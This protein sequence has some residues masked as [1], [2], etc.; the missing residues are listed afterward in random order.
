MSPNAPAS[1]LGFHTL[2]IWWI[3]MIK[4]IRCM[5]VETKFVIII[6]FIWF[7]DTFY[8]TSVSVGGGWCAE[9][10]WPLTSTSMWAKFAL[11]AA[12]R[13]NSFNSANGRKETWRK[14]KCSLIHIR[15]TSAVAQKPT[16][17]NQ[18]WIGARF[19]DH[20]LLKVLW[21]PSFAWHET[22]IAP[23]PLGTPLGP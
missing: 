18:I 10:T 23:Y 11:L 22:P 15:Y 19:E 14:F 4:H 20:L 6:N 5:K 8:N 17:T 9:K 3:L 12:I 7:S 13:S 16:T 2:M 1:N 21:F